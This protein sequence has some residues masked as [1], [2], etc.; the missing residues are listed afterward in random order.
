MDN[1]QSLNTL[2]YMEYIVTLGEGMVL[3]ANKRIRIGFPFQDLVEFFFRLHFGKRDA[4]LKTQLE[5]RRAYMLNRIT[6][7]FLNRAFTQMEQS[8]NLQN[9]DDVAEHIEDYFT[10]FVK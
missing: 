6:L 7:W 10:Y 9:A 4:I 2:T 1:D 5:Q 3:T 8:G